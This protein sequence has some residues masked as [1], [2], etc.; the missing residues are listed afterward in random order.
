MKNNIIIV[1]VFLSLFFYCILAQ[2]SNI[3][4]RCEQLDSKSTCFKYLNYTSIFIPN[5]I[6]QAS[7]ETNV[8]SDLS[9][10]EYSDP[11]C[12]GNGTLVYCLKS[13]PI[14]NSIILPD[15][16]TIPLPS[17]P[18]N[19]LCQNAYTACEFYIKNYNLPL[20]CDS[21]DS[22]GN[23]E[24]PIEYTDY[25]LTIVGGLPVNHIQCANS[26]L[27]NQNEPTEINC[28]DPLV[29]IDPSYKDDPVIYWVSDYCALPC[30]MKLFSEHEY[31]VL[32][33]V[34]K[35]FY[36]LSFISSVFLII[37]FGVLPNIVS[38]RME[39]ILSY[40]VCTFIISMTYFVEDWYPENTFYCSDQPGRFKTQGDHLC[41]SNG[42]FFQLAA[43]GVIFWATAILYEIYLNS[44][45][46]QNIYFKYIRIF[47]WS[48]VVL[49]ALIPLFKSKYSA[50]VFSGCWIN[51]DNGGAWQYVLFYIPAWICLL[52][53]AYFSIY[54]SIKIY[55]MYKLSPN[56]SILFWNVKLLFFLLL[57]LFNLVF[58]SIFK[59]YFES[60]REEYLNL[61]RLWAH[62]LGENGADA[63]IL[64]IPGYPLRLLN[65]ICISILGLSLFL[66]FGFDPVTHQIW[67]E[68][69]KIHFIIS[70]LSFLNRFVLLTSSSSSNSND[71]KGT[72][73]SLKLKTFSMDLFHSSGSSTETKSENLTSDI[74]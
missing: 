13:F 59:F 70:K 10:L 51:S 54:S 16:S 1:Y 63:C 2:S 29:K 37:T 35:V 36:T 14:C 18:C 61:V 28:L 52:L 38:T 15:N 46:Q 44:K 4:G 3:V 56:N 33:Y 25:N 22:R 60:K 24:Y 5:G 8:T 23:K 43:L 30:N 32:Y 20:S 72:R 68:S 69:K 31:T 74:N 27:L 47:N 6:T 71:G 73:K 40:S 62:C 21:V 39:S 34:K 41:G 55:V 53:M 45:I 7:I 57:S 26:S 65:T 50:T 42:F 58:G 67:S 17:Y 9:F 49:F 64:Q 66:A 48:V 12:K 19:N 11:S